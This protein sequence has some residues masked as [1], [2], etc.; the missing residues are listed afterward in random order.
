[1]SL[2]AAG[3]AQQT[4]PSGQS[5]LL[6]NALLRVS[7]VDLPSSP[8]P[9]AAARSDIILIAL[10]P[11][12][13]TV[14]TA[15]SIHSDA[16]DAR[17]VRAGNRLV[18]A[19]DASGAS[20]IIVV[21]KKHWDAEVRYCELPARCTRENGLGPSKI[22]ETTSLFTNGFITAMR[23]RVFANGSLESS[24]YSQR[25]KDSILLLALTD[26]TADCAGIEQ[27]LKQGQVYF[28]TAGSVNVDGGKTGAEWVVVRFNEP[29]GSQ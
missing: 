16:G 14:D 20:L 19:R 18:V 17:F 26:M 25:G 21:L 9:L 7:R 28:T 2:V 24:Y 12:A 23:H 13:V 11:V 29:K 5:V 27:P 10:A 4:A 1:V 3:F 15:A 6:D 22:S 8:L